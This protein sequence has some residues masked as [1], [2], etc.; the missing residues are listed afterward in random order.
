MSDDEELSFEEDEGDD[1]EED[2]PAEKESN[3]LITDLDGRNKKE[4]RVQKAQLWF[5]KVTILFYKIISSFFLSQNCDLLNYCIIFRIYSVELKPRP[6]KTLS[7][8]LLHLNSNRK[9][10]KYWVRSRRMTTN[11]IQM[12]NQMQHLKQVTTRCLRCPRKEPMRKWKT[13]P[14]HLKRVALKLFPKMVK[15]DA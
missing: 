1:S 5:Q 14:K 12:M 13:R 7:L 3:P 2:D 11:T 15:L 8:M 4:K 9:A 6:T 10:A